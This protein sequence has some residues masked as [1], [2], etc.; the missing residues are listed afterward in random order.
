[1]AS[2]GCI[3]L[4]CRCIVYRGWLPE[5]TI[6]SVVHIVRHAASQ[7]RPNVGSP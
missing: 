6:A 2:A 5:T 3:A 7:E 4:S 1:M